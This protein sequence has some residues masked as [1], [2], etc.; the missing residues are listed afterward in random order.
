[1]R[2]W[3]KL[4][5]I[6]ILLTV[7][8]LII[9]ELAYQGPKVGNKNKPT[10]PIGQPD[11]KPK[12]SIDLPSFEDR[13]KKEDK[14]KKVLP[15]LF[16]ESTKREK[17]NRNR[18]S[19]TSPNRNTDSASGPRSNNR[20]QSGGNRGGGG[21]GSGSGNG[22]T[23][24]NSSDPVLTEQEKQNQFPQAAPAFWLEKSGSQEYNNTRHNKTCPRFMRVPGEPCQEE[25]GLT[26]PD[27]KG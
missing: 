11:F 25:D 7:G 15:P 19:A 12:T 3:L 14:T 2:N 23:N 5:G 22:G 20:S 17:T 26:C 18:N 4:V 1:M 13:S 27:C 8:V 24:S 21:G 9:N 10:S 16:T 6:A